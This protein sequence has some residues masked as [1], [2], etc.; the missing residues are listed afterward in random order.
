MNVE[1]ISVID[2][3]IKI[4]LG[5]LIAGVFTQ[6]TAKRQ[7]ERELTK[8]RTE[9]NRSLIKDIVINIE[10][11]TIAQNKLA[12]TLR[13][14]VYHSKFPQSE[15]LAQSHSCVLDAQNYLNVAMANSVLLGLSDVYTE[16]K[17][18]SSTLN[19]MLNIIDDGKFDE[20]FL[21]KMQVI[22]NNQVSVKEKINK[23]IATAY[24]NA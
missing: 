24:K 9:D 20:E 17:N 2:S 22:S 8:Q 18:Y 14:A 12:G 10:N 13:Q 11:S 1:I 7:F 15:A 23:L 19:A 5:A 16:I 4:G 6:L 3:A 21:S